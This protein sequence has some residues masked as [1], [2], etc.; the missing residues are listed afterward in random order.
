MHSS[1]NLTVLGV[2]PLGLG[3]KG[4]EVG[5]A[6]YRDNNSCH[7]QIQANMV[8]HHRPPSLLLHRNK[9]YHSLVF[10]SWAFL[11]LSNFPIWGFRID[12]YGV[13]GAHQLNCGHSDLGMAFLSDV[14]R[15]VFQASPSVFRIETIPPVHHWCSITQTVPLSKSPPILAWVVLT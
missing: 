10:F 1:L 11:F 7:L 3:P 4:P 6:P 2:N 8:A 14:T 13:H 12:G 9:L 15:C 5:E